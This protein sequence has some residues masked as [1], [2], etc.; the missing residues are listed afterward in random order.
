[1]LSSQR[2]LERLPEQNCIIGRGHDPWGNPGGSR[3][4]W[5]IRKVALEGGG[6]DFEPVRVYCVARPG[7]LLVL[8]YTRK[9]WAHYAQLYMGIR[10]DWTI[11]NLIV[12]SKGLALSRLCRVDAQ[13]MIA[14]QVA[15]DDPYEFTART[16][17]D[18]VLEKT[19]SDDARIYAS[20]WG[21]YP[22]TKEIEWEP[23][24]GDGDGWT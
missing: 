5:V 10:A 22:S 18:L 12:L 11:P 23:S 19:A 17:D 3:V 6:L 2:F 8:D 1:M 9:V 14:I 4:W 7:V 20:I 24:T 15:L 16:F 13:H 21:I